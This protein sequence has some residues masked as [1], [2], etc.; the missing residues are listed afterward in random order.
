MMDI[1]HF[2]DLSIELET[3]LSKNYEALASVSGDDS[4]T[5]RLKSLAAEELNHANILRLGKN[6]YAA[7]PDLF[8]G[9]TVGGKE[10][11]TGIAR[12][13]NLHASLG[14]GLSLA[15]GLEKMLL[16][17]RRFERVH[18]DTSVKLNNPSLKKLFVDLCH[19]DR[20]HV[21]VLQGMIASLRSA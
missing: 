5:K 12:A 10:V 20:N 2:L 4:L 18:L 9:V 17:E 3:Q 15:D 8:A 6:Y 16:L 13:A 19:G 11:Q 14:Q 7:M 1:S 21:C